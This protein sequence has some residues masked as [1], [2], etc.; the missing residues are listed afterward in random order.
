MVSLLKRTLL[1]PII[2]CFLNYCVKDEVDSSMIVKLFMVPNVCDSNLIF[3]SFTIEL[4][5]N[6][7]FFF[8]RK[9]T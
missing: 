6:S 5:K 4:L 8:L 3:P 2:K 9:K 1:A 7:F